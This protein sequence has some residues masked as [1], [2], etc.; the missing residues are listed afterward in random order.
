[1][2]R[3][4]PRVLRRLCLLAATA[5]TLSACATGNEE[6]A[7]QNV[8]ALVSERTNVPVVWHKDEQSSERAG[9][10]VR[11]LLSQ[12]LTKNGAIKL[13]FLRNPAIQA[14]LATIGISEADVAQAGRVKNP[15]ISIERV[16][17]HGFLEINRQVL[18]S[19]L[20][21]ATIG[22]RTEI[23]KSRSGTHPVHGG[24]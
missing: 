9:Y 16:V 5:L 18:F 13:A 2:D 17:T 8:N 22:G 19:V 12:P 24:A 14:S 10:E 23:A 21:L 20:S 11:N 7:F 6:M 4:G 3:C 15:V 1:M